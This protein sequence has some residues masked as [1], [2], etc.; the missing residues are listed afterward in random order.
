MKYNEMGW[1]KRM[2]KQMKKLAGT[3]VSLG[4]TATLVHPAPPNHTANNN[5]K[6]INNNTSNVTSLTQSKNDIDSH[7]NEL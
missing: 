4:I 7:K 3:L 6:S 5:T 2:S 1:I